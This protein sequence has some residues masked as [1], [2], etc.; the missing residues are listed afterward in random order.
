MDE[1]WQCISG[2]DNHCCH[3]AGH[4][5]SCDDINCIIQSFDADFANRQSKYECNDLKQSFVSIENAQ[6]D[7][8]FSGDADIDKIENYHLSH[9]N[10][11]IAFWLHSS[12]T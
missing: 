7:I 4:V 5:D 3:N 2:N 6:S 12:C 8:T 11:K 9:L 10:K 1:F